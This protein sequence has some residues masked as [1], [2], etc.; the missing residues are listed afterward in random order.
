LN[1]LSNR[2]A[3]YTF[4]TAKGLP[5]RSKIGKIDKRKSSILW[6]VILEFYTL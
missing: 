2:S 5:H 3:L 1:G 6:P 4:E